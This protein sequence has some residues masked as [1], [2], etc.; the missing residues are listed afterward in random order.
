MLAQMPDQNHHM[1]HHI[2]MGEFHT[3]K[4]SLANIQNIVK[5]VIVFD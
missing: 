5:G 1:Y 2:D 4:H 3:Q